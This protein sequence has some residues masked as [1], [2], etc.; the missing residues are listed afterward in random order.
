MKNVD[1]AVGDDLH[2]E[3]LSLSAGVNRDLLTPTITTQTSPCWR[4][5]TMCLQASIFNA[6]ACYSL[7]NCYSAIMGNQGQR[8]IFSTTI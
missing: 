5:K 7:D 8:A 1:N 2:E 4:V 6:T 3:I